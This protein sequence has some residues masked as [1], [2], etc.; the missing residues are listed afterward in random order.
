MCLKTSSR[1]RLSLGV[2]TVNVYSSGGIVAKQ[3]ARFVAG[4]SPFVDA[5]PGYR[6]ESE[7]GIELLRAAAAAAA[8]GWKLLFPG[9]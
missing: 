2:S 8:A 1:A 5:V 3:T 7:P 4:R 6:D 9:R